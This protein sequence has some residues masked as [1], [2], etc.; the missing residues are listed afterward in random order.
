M[1]HNAFALSDIR[2]DLRLS[3]TLACIT[4]YSNWQFF[5]NAEYAEGLVILRSVLFL[6][7]IYS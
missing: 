2:S 7:N 4:L 6:S 1:M 5:D 3:F